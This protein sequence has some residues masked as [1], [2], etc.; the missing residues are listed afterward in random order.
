MDKKIK[1]NIKYDYSSIEYFNKNKLDENTKNKIKKILKKE[2][3]KSK[4]N[5]YKINN[6]KQQKDK[7]KLKEENI[8]KTEQDKKEGK[9][10]TKQQVPAPS[11]EGQKE[12]VSAQQASQDE[13]IDRRIT[14][15]LNNA[16]IEEIK[17]FEKQVASSSSKKKTEALANLNQEKNIFKRLVYNIIY[18]NFFESSGEKFKRKLLKI[19]ILKRSIKIANLFMFLTV[20]GGVF[21]TFYGV[22]RFFDAYS[23]QEQILTALSVGLLFGL[24]VFIFT[25]LNFKICIKDSVFEGAIIHYY[26]NKKYKINIKYLMQAI[27][28]AIIPAIVVSI[29]DRFIFLRFIPAFYTT[30]I[31]LNVIYNLFSNIFYFGITEEILA[32][33]FVTSLVFKLILNLFKKTEKLKKGLKKEQIIK[34]VY[35]LTNI[36]STILFAVLNFALF[37]LIFKMTFLIGFKILITSVIIGFFANSLYFKKGL[38]YN[39]AFH[40]AFAVLNQ[41]ILILI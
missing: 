33:F 39:I 3:K 1:K 35:F 30:N 8:L 17:E 37:V 38:E 15:K 16:S 24:I 22:N 23:L 32:R 10:E 18:K 25:I 6:K 11:N 41:I 27:A 19:E 9:K 7:E 29:I 21:L 14:I 40:I 2:N 12:P 31:G 36:F 5:K 20:L 26:K 28:I 34:K 4:I 13:E